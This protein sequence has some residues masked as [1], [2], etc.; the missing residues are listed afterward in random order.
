MREDFRVALN[1]LS[2]DLKREIH[3][4]RDSFMGEITKIREEFEDEVSTL[5]QVIK[6]LQADMALCKRSLASGDGNTNHGLKID[7]PKPSPFVGKRKARAVDDFL[8][9][10]EQYLEGVNVVDDASKIKIAT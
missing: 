7:V 10:M 9:E 3:D 1:T 2:G 8:W 4:L 6:A 5:H